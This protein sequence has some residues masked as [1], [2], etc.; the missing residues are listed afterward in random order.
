MYA[1]CYDVN[2]S[3]IEFDAE[4]GKYNKKRRKGVYEKLLCKKCEEIIQEYEDYGKFILYD[5]AKPT[6]GAT[7]KPYTN[8]KY[9]YRLFK[10][11]VLSLLWRASIS[12]Q[13]SFKFVSLGKY[14]EE[15][16][17]M[18]LN[19]LETPINNYPIC[20]YQTHINKNPSNGVFMEIYPSKSKYDG[21]TVYQFI[22]DGV[23]F[24]VGVRFHSLKIFKH[25]SWVN[26][27]RIQIGYDELTKLLSLVD[28]FVRLHRQG[29]FSVYEKQT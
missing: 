11:F 2:H 4:K 24:F 14:E 3:Y 21:R 27:K 25:G 9:D 26:Q 8:E 28:V 22:A 5:D 23:F 19:G 12:T 13:N 29:K 10:L 18:L 1:H 20:M 7:P 17:V 6:I 16:R 15:L